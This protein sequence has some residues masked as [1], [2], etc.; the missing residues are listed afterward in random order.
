MCVVSLWWGSELEVGEVW[1]GGVIRSL[2]QFRG[3]VIVGGG[4]CLEVRG[5]LTTGLMYSLLHLVGFSFT[6]LS[7]MHGHSN[8]KYAIGSLHISN[9]YI[10]L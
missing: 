3:C 4:W 10:M 8:I 7:K 9:V 2:G 1:G 6:Y 5:S